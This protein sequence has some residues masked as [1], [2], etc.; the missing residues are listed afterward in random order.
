MLNSIYCADEHNHPVSTV[1]VEVSYIVKYE[2]LNN[3]I[4]VGSTAISRANHNGNRWGG[5]EISTEIQEGNLC[6]GKPGASSGHGKYTSVMVNLP[7]PKTKQNT[8]LNL[9]IFLSGVTY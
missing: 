7:H 2:E 8:F 1:Q 4:R 5:N 6:S 3:I 9:D